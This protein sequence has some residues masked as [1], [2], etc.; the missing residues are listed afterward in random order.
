M[1]CSVSG[2]FNEYLKLMKTLDEAKEETTIKSA[3]QVNVTNTLQ[4]NCRRLY[5][6]RSSTTTMVAVHNGRCSSRPLNE[7]VP[8]DAADRNGSGFEE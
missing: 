5:R 7:N 4:S 8:G 1:Q 6:H 2:W 3:H